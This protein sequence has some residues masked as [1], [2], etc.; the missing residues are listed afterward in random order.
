M[1]DGAAKH[2]SK[3]S[4]AK[5]QPSKVASRVQQRMAKPAERSNETMAQP[6][7][8]NRH[9]VTAERSNGYLFHNRSPP[10]NQQDRPLFFL[11]EEIGRFVAKRRGCCLSEASF[12]PF[13][14]KPPDFSK[15]NAALTFCFFSVKG[16]EKAPP[17]Y[18]P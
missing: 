14:Y 17:T 2:I 13:R 5:A 6:R 11:R 9:E 10:Q 4:E 7:K 3:A 18:H 16:K 8:K 12:T 1:S 15:K